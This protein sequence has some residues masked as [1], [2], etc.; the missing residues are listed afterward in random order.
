MSTTKVSIRL[1]VE[2]KAE[3]KRAFDEIGQSGQAA[4][5]QVDK[6]IDKTGAAT[7]RET[8]RLKRL[9]EAARMAAQADA[10]Q[11]RFNQ[12]LGVGRPASGSAR[13]SAEV[14][15]QA[16]REAEAFEARAKALRAAL[17]PLAAAQDRL[18][19]ELN[20]YATLARAGSITAKE[21]AA[22]QA[23]A[24]QRFD[25]T[26]RAMQAGGVSAGMMRQRMM[27]LNYTVNDTIASLASGGS[28]LTILLQQGPQ[29]ADA[30]GGIGP[31]FRSVGAAMMGTAGIVTALAGAVVVGGLAWLSYD[32]STR[33]VAT[34]LQGA[35]RQSGATRAELEASAISAAEAGKVSVS[36]AREMQVA[37]LATGRVGAEEMGRA[38]A[39]SR[40]FAVTMGVE[41][42]DGARQLASALADP[43]RGFDQINERLAFLDDRTRQYVRTLVE[44]GNRTEAQ[45]VL[46]ERLKPALADAEQSVNALSRAWNWVARNASDAWDAMGK[47]I[48]RAVNG[49]NATEELQLRLWQRGQL[50]DNM[51]RNG[52]EMPLMLPQVEA[53]IA[54]L[55]RQLG[56][57]RQR[58]AAAQAEAR[59]NARSVAAGEAARDLMP[60]AREL[61]RLQAQQAALRA[62]LDDPLARSKLADLA[63][64]EAAFNRVTAAIYQ[65]TG[66]LGA[67]GRAEALLRSEQEVSI[68]TTLALANAYLQ[69]GAVAQ[70]QAALNAGIM[71]QL[72]EGKD[73]D[74]AADQA[75][76]ES[77][78]NQTLAG[79]QQV[80]ELEAQAA[81]QRR[82]NEAVRSGAISQAQAAQALQA[83]LALRPLIVAQSLAEGDAK[84]ALTRIIERMR[85]AYGELNTTQAAG[86]GLAA[87]DTKAQEIA[88]L[89]RQIALVNESVTVR[90]NAIAQMRAEQELRQRGIALGT[91]EAQA[92]LATAVQIEQLNRVLAGKQALVD[93]G[94]EIRLLEAQLRLIGATV[95]KRAEELAILRARNQLEQRGIDP[96]S[97]EGRAGIANA[98][99]VDQLNRT[100]TGRQAVRD[101]QDEID[102]LRTQISL[103]GESASQRAVILAQ[104]RM[105]QSLRGRGIDL[106]S[107]EGRQLVERAGQIERLTQ[108]L[109]KQDAATRALENAFSAG[110]DRFAEVLA[111]GKTDW[112]SWA[113]AGRAALMD[114]NRELIKLAVLNPLKNLLFG[115]NNPTI[116]NAGGW[117]GSLIRGFGFHTGGL[118]GVGGDPRLVPASVFA[119]APRFHDGVF[120]KP[121]EVPAIL[122]RGERVLNRAETRDYQRGRRGGGMATVNVTIQTPNPSAFDASRTQIAAGLARAVQ[123]G[124]RGM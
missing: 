53:R 14:F 54:E 56:I 6:A 108:E 61:E 100:L 66:S 33:A 32:R 20:E 120:L 77:L 112:K 119:G 98:L 115:Q 17:D 75:L 111:Q 90:G 22:A 95:A 15:E 11:G 105:E 8:A 46:L 55:E 124:M 91:A 64:V 21:H 70:R 9:A 80:A 103:V 36:A 102:L 69:G 30:W 123:S 60:G 81:A 85:S 7:E 50:Q 84:V 114:I 107:E 92:Y 78:A 58:T 1:G 117:I 31:L 79:A 37:F 65:Y 93:Q 72:R 89:Q 5:A 40:D 82:V 45:R 94:R 59:A 23:M 38:I 116:Q 109:Q 35:G 86:Q 87:T 121:D 24:R 18:N 25:E 43:I 10:A 76:R 26:A 27:A 118:V 41:T 47:A 101:Q 3:V 73:R 39:I 113:D 16:A 34:A 96:A 104:L 44:Q 63:Q 122:Q 2:G 29:V 67:A 83:E 62:A 49:R 68:R 42:A 28:P 88:L 99:R 57:E 71:A 74:V 52:G 19:G 106:A 51:R 4:F 48:D 97:E 110:L 12:V 13:A